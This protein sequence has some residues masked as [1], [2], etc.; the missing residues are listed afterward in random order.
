MS[1]KNVH[2]T[3]FFYCK[4]RIS[5]WIKKIRFVKLYQWKHEGILYN[6]VI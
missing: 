4:S 5:W 3:L 1:H 2:A 6:V